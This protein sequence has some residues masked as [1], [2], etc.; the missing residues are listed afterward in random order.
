MKK[1]KIIPIILTQVTFLL[2][3]AFTVLNKTNKVVEIN[4]NNDASTTGVFV[5]VTDPN[6][7]LNANDRIIIVGTDWEGNYPVAFQELSQDRTSI[8]ATS[9]SASNA[10]LFTDN[11]GNKSYLINNSYAEIFTVSH[12]FDL[13]SFAFK[14]TSSFSNYIRDV[15]NSTNIEDSSTKDSYS[16]WIIEP[17][18]EDHNGNFLRNAETGNHFYNTNGGSFSHTGFYKSYIHIYKQVS[19]SVETKIAP[20]RLDY[21]VFDPI[22]YTGLVTTVSYNDG[23]NN[24]KIDVAYDEC[25]GI[26]NCPSEISP[27]F[28]T[29]SEVDFTV[30]GKTANF[31]PT[32]HDR[33]VTLSYS[34]VTSPLNDYRGTYHFVTE[35][36]S[37]VFNP[38]ELNYHDG[39]FI[40]VV[41]SNH[42]ID[43]S[44][45]A[46]HYSHSEMVIRVVREIVSNETVYYL[47]TTT[48][49][50]LSFGSYDIELLL[51][52]EPSSKVL[53][54]D[55]GDI[56]LQGNY[57]T[58]TLY[59][60]SDPDNASNSHFE[61]SDTNKHGETNYY[62]VYLYKR[63]MDNELRSYVDAFKTL[64]FNTTSVCDATGATNNITLEAWANLAT[65]FNSVPIDVK[66]DFQGYFANLTY[67]HSSESHGYDEDVVDRYDY[68]I[69]KYTYLDD[70][71]GRKIADTYQN[72]YNPRNA[73]T[74]VS[75]D[76]NQN[77]TI[78]VLIS[79]SILFVASLSV[80]L[81]L[82]K[83]NN[84]NR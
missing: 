1:T 61:F 66:E 35:D 19:Y 48:G 6:N 67:T 32:I 24:C 54:E 13:A 64:F 84:I 47:K 51:T 62:P 33:N 42:S 53:F 70:F 82:K 75:N 26:F 10:H 18:T 81:F 38:F 76:A 8:I 21:Y 11:Q 34:K 9:M 23:T 55:N 69:S 49:K 37:K 72:N 63:D 83:K 50:Y 40:D 4:A 73:I 5:E 65:N 31:K 44:S 22:D 78:V 77:G 14:G 43:A 25:S 28:A 36:G 15:P 52:N 3:G 2:A 59:F 17:D 39:G 45:T 41:I 29:Y 56:K 57:G 20:N 27:V 12:G 74:M 60:Y 80:C 79:V 46:Y 68:I 30:L 58:Y 7:D 16:T 71:M